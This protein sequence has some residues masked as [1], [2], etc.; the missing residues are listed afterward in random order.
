M[1]VM[2]I[3]AAFAINLAHIQLVGTEMQVAT[4]A[5]ARAAS[6]VFTSSGDFDRA[7]AVAQSLANRNLVNSTPLQ[8]KSSDF[9]FGTST[10]ESLGQR[11]RYQGSGGA[12]NALHLRVDKKAGSPSG[13]VA[14]AFPSF[15][16]AQFS[17]LSSETIVT[18]VELDI[19]LVVDRSGS[20]A[21]AAEEKAAY[22]PN[23]AFAPPG[24]D[25]GKP[26]PSPSRWLDTVNAVQVFLD[27]LAR[28][29]QRERV[30][31]VTYAGSA[32]VDHDLTED[33]TAP[34][35]ALAKYSAKFNS[36][37]TNI[38]AGMQSALNRL[39]S[40][41]KSRPW[42][43]KVIVVMTDGIYTQGTN[44]KTVAESIAKEGVMVFAVTFAAEANQG[45]MKEVAIAGGGIHYHARNAQDL[46]NV[47]R[48][49]ARN[50][51]ILISH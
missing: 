26:V 27:E 23:P 19:A 14:L 20:M 32:V 21:Y 4:D 28:S 12:R 46:T 3:L 45:T 16:A 11:Y 30:T 10:R 41:S 13:P 8:L 38:G 47:F 48:E 39:A 51:P 31:L 6:K 36:G 18:Q 33:Y 40:S 24:W 15:G 9:S 1:I 35:R 25:F 7:H 44:P 49:V 34:I 22:P 29:P 43:T 5:S 17:Q 50:M 37:D 42:A 2:L